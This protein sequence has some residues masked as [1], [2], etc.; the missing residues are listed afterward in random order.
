MPFSQESKSPQK[1]E[2]ESMMEDTEESSK[3][4]RDDDERDEDEEKKKMEEMMEPMALDG[5]SKKKEERREEEEEEELKAGDGGT[6]TQLTPVRLSSLLKRS[7]I[8]FDQ[9][10]TPIKPVLLRISIWGSKCHVGFDMSF[11]KW[12]Q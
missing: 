12:Y 4:D 6:Q 8:R 11:T 1:A 3:M 5:G 10:T 7:N 9:S 2:N